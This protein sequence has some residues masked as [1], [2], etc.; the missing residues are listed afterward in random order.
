VDAT[1][2]NIA[3]HPLEVADGVV[4]QGR[5]VLR[6]NNHPVSGFLLLLSRLFF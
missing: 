3:E 4:V 6:L 2:R 5:E 1:L